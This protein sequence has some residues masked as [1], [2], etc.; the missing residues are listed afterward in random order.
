LAVLESFEARDPGALRDLPQLAATL[1]A[2]YARH[3]SRPSL[4]GG[5]AAG[6]LRRGFRVLRSEGVGGLARR[7]RKRG[8]GA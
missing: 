5:S 7:A 8:R 2:A 6:V 4:D 1:A 3:E